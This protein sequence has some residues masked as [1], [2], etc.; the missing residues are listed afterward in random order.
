MEP[1]LAAIVVINEPLGQYYGGTVA[2]PAFSRI[3]ERALMYLNVPQDRP[4][5]PEERRPG[6]PAAKPGLERARGLTLAQS[7][8]R[9][10]LAADA[11]KSQDASWVEESES[12]DNLEETVL[13]LIGDKQP[14]QRAAHLVTV[15]TDSV[16]LPDFTGWNLRD[17]A[18]E[19]A[20]LGLRMKTSGAGTAVAQRPPAGSRVARQT[21]CEVYFSTETVRTSGA[22]VFAASPESSV[23]ASEDR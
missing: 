17:V 18:R 6:I 8:A 4:I 11:A 7:T 2:A 22:S 12:P 13:S 21:V 1:R 20:R 15:S 3:M 9:R 19:G 10:R 14:V 16:Q 5:P 23:P